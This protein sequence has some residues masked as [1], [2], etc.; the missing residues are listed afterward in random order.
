MDRLKQL[1]WQSLVC[2]NALRFGLVLLFFKGVLLL[3]GLW[4]AGYQ[5]ERQGS[6]IEDVAGVSELSESFVEFDKT[7]IEEI[8]L[9]ALNTELIGQAS[10]QHPQLRELLNDRP[11]SSI[12]VDDGSMM[13]KKSSI[14]ICSLKELLIQ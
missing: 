4:G 11:I 14:A 8:H 9:A 13:H 1:K 3:V 6:R 10:G 7:L 12:H 2:V 5:L